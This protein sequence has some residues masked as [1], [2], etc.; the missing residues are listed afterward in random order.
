MIEGYNSFTYVN[1]F[2]PFHDLLHLQ[3]ITVYIIGFPIEVV[4]SKFEE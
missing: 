1:G 4:G 2:I 3:R